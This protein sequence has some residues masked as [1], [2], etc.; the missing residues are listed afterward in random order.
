MPSAK[1]KP[2]GTN[3]PKP[4]NFDSKNEEV[5]AEL[6]QFLNYTSLSL[7]IRDAEDDGRAALRILNCHYAGSTKPRIIGLYTELTSLVKST[8]DSITDYVI[9]TEKTAAAL[10]D[11]GEV[12]SDSLLI[13]IVLKGLPT[14]YR[15]FSVAVSQR[16]LITEGEMTFTEFKAMLRI[17]SS[18]EETE[19]GRERSDSAM[20]NNVNKWKG[21]KP[22][23]QGIKKEY[24]P[25]RVPVCWNCK[26]PRHVSKTAKFQRL[27][28]RRSKTSHLKEAAT[29]IEERE[30]LR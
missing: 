3:N 22:K 5:F 18:Y 23:S 19:A 13:A 7:V 6:I 15:P 4:E 12:I 21:S 28:N 11:T 30:E 1:K 27:T 10:R 24:R 25:D 20:Y 26:N 17:N 14:D 29:T 2:E 16:D 9:K 8:S